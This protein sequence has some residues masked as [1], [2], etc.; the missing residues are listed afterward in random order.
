M[1]VRL[2]F[3]VAARGCQ[4]RSNFGIHPP[5][6][7]V[8][9]S[10]PSGPPVPSTPCRSLALS[11]DTRA[12]H[13]R[14]VSALQ[15]ALRMALWPETRAWRQKG[16]WYPHAQERPEALLIGVAQ[17]RAAARYSDDSASRAAGA[18]G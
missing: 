3:F 9:F 7:E 17:S 15:H 8:T 1:H 6:T 11:I 5:S 10:G 2:E 4:R 16:R 13:Q 12:R 18:A 14:L